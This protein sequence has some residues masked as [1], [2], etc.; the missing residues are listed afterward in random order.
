MSHSRSRFMINTAALLAALTLGAAEAAALT[1]RMTPHANRIVNLAQTPSTVVVSNPLHA[2]VTVLDRKLVIQAR[3]V[4]TTNIMVL[5]GK[6]NR[7]A[8]FDVNVVPQ[9]TNRMRVYYAGH[10]V[11]Y[12]CDPDCAQVLTVGDYPN[13]FSTLQGQMA[14]ATGN[15]GGDASSGPPAQ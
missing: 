10:R 8:T 7:L 1:L 4:G 14:A 5:D 11:T 9:T 3:N 12:K 6:G 13:A 15:G 2:D